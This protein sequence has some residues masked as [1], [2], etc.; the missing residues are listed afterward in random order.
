M[1]IKHL[2]I[3][4]IVAVSLAGCFNNNQTPN[5]LASSSGNVTKVSSDKP[6]STTSVLNFE[7]AKLTIDLPATTD[8]SSSST[9]NQT[10]VTS[11]FFNAISSFTL[12]DVCQVQT[13]TGGNL[14]R[15]CRCRYEWP[16][17]NQSDSSS[18]SRS[19]ETKPTDITNFDVKCPVP[20]VYNNEIP[21]G[22]NIKISLVPAA[23]NPSRF[24][25]TVHTFTKQAIFQTG[26]FRDAEGRSY[27]NIYHYVCF[28]KLPKS[29]RI[30]H[31]NKDLSVGGITVNRPVANAFKV[32]GSSS[33]FS[34]QSY[35]Y[36]FYVRSNE[37]GSIN[38]TTESFTCPK[39]NIG[40][41]T[42]F[43]PR[44]TTFAL[45]L[46]PS[47]DFPL[48]VQSRIV[49]SN[50]SLQNTILGYAAKP[51]SDGTCPAFKN[52]NNQAQN[53]YR[54][55]QYKMVYPIRYSANGDV[56]DQSQP[57]NVIFVMDR[58]VSKANQ[59]PQK[60]ITRLGP[61]PCPFSFQTA[62]FGRR[63]MT[64]AV[65]NGWSIDGTQVDGNASCPIYPPVPDKHL[66]ADGTLVIRPFKSFL[67][68]YIEDTSFK[69][70]AFQSSS[71][72]DPEI[73][74]SHDDGVNGTQG[75]HDFYCAKHYPAAG[76]IASSQGDAFDKAPG[77]CDLAQTAGRIKSSLGYSCSK[78]YDPTSN[79]S[80]APSAGCC[81]ICAGSNCTAQG[82][83]TTAA[84]RN[85]AFSPPQDV[86]NP[87]QA[88]KLVPRAA[89]NIN[90]N[91]CFDPTE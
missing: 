17:T 72:I 55:R 22:T 77:D 27:K 80:I 13:S 25:T 51:N 36:D 5:N 19:A 35:Y 6:S 86:G 40:S 73:V 79:S 66:K 1:M 37:L 21:D 83:G 59:D 44:D 84:G 52:A 54:L 82:G 63:C 23:T 58:P 61:K 89:P 81:Q 39:V 56:L 14:S 62:Q 20:D 88:I 42:D 48:T 18:I 26:T 78:T 53:T 15:D 47:K 70:C 75:P 30:G 90:T 29:L 2:P 85:L 65:L 76:A 45:A 33:S 38:S 28:D 60:P 32:T 49:I 31:D 9:A 12:S 16:E 46:N 3:I 34:G 91:G 87:A 67:P 24:T 41:V 57:F 10:P 43:Y 69:A 4:I 68:Y 8:T 7:I 50:A 71:P 64:D 74:L 11:M